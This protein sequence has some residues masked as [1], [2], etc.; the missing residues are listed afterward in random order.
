V[1]LPY[2]IAA[3]S[4]TVAAAAL[5]ILLPVVFS[6]VILAIPQQAHRE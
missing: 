6:F 4:I 5:K 1:A 2:T 3:T